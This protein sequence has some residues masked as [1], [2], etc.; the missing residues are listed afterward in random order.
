MIT[1]HKKC[2]ASG[3]CNTGSPFCAEHLRPYAD[4]LLSEIAKQESEIAK[5]K[6]GYWQ[7]INVNGGPAQEFMRVVRERTRPTI[8]RVS[9]ECFSDLSAATSY[10]R[11]LRH[12]G[13]IECGRNARGGTVVYARKRKVT[14]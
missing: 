12:A 7:E 11:A 6:E 3:C 10:M 2:P 1:G 9:R 8:E 13:L 4:H 14:A 5:A